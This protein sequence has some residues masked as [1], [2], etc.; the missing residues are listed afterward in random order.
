MVQTDFGDSRHQCAGHRVGGVTAAAK[1]GLQHHQIALFPCKP[2]QRQRGDCLEFHRALAALRLDLLHRVQHLPGQRGEGSRRDHLPVDLKALPEIRHKGA[3][4]QAGLVPGL[5]E[6]AADHRR[7]AA[8]AVG[9]RDMHTGQLRFGVAQ[10][11]QKVLHTGQ[12]GHTAHAGQ[13][14]Q[15]LNGLLSGHGCSSL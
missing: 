15:R 13:C 14:V 8:L 2:E 12:R 9:A 11:R 3:D 4:R 10:M 7:E 6:D 1:A 5:G